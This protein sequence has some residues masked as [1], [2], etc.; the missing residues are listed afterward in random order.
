MLLNSLSRFW[1]RKGRHLPLALV[2]VSVRFAMF[3]VFKRGTDPQH[4]IFQKSSKKYNNGWILIFWNLIPQKQK[5]FYS[6]PLSIRILIN[7]MVF[8]LTILVSGFPK[9]LNF[10]EFTLI[11]ILILVLIHLML[12][13]RLCITWKTFKDQKIPIKRRYRK[14]CPCYDQ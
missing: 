12:H 7:W 5:L 3:F 11:I 1:I 6:V 14:S 4:S 10:W 13:H 9:K 2:G 8:L